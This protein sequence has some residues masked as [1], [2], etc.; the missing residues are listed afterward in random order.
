MQDWNIQYKDIIAE[1][2]EIKILTEERKQL[3]NAVNKNRRRLRTKLIKYSFLEDLI[4][5]ETYYTKMENAVKLYFNEF[6]YSEVHNIS[7]DG[8][9]DLR[10]FIGT[11]KLI[12]IEVTASDGCNVKEDTVGQLTKRMGLRRIQFKGFKLY[13]CTIVSHDFKKPYH[14]RCKEP[15]NK[16]LKEYAETS[17]ISLV[18]TTDLVNAFIDIKTGKVKP[19]ALIN[20]ICTSGIFKD[21]WVQHKLEISTLKD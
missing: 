20:I 1:L 11:N 2:D 18:T 17:E 10:C 7:K 13:G 4:G 16:K 3:L 5:V 6:G 15:F 9:E 14:K 12:L 19:E 21:N 8:E